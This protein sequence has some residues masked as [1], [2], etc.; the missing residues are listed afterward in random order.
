ML[1]KNATQNNASGWR[2]AIAEAGQILR[3]GL[4]PLTN[5]RSMTGISLIAVALATTGCATLTSPSA[6]L[7]TAANGDHGSQTARQYHPAIDFNGRL[8]LRYQQDGKEQALHGSFTWSQASQRTLVTLLS[9]LGQTLATID[10]TPQQSTLHQAGQPPRS[11]ADVDLLTAQAL[12]W[13]LPIAGL[14]DWLQGFGS[15]IN[16]KRFNIQPSGEKEPTNITTADHW[17]IQYTGWQPAEGLTGDA[18]STPKRIDLTRSTEQ[19]GE[20]AIRIVVDSA[21]I[22]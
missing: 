6:P 20:V 9:P 19:A 3:S 21:Q 7:T 10:I 5:L 18:N 15:D 1:V 11:A 14:R 22:H 17:A 4:A 16:G 8:S 12:G 2:A 13:P